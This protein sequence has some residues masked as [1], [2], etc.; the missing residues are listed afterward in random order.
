MTV[1]ISSSEML[2]T[3]QHLHVPVHKNRKNESH[4]KLKSL[5]KYSLQRRQEYTLLNLPKKYSRTILSTNLH[6]KVLIICGKICVVILVHC[7][8][9]PSPFHSCASAATKSRT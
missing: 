3:S 1:A 9:G 5:L 8:V 7:G 6:I 2:A 4:R